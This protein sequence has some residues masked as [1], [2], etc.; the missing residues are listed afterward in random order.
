MMWVFLMTSI[1][2]CVLCIYLFCYQHTMFL[3]SYNTL[4]FGLCI[5]ESL[6]TWVYKPVPSMLML[7][8][9]PTESYSLV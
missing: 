9:V 2:T 7:F 4:F 8:L 6:V 5:T 1:N 3:V